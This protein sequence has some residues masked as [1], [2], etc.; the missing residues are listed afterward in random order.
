MSSLH[1]LSTF[2]PSV[3]PSCARIKLADNVGIALSE[4]AQQDP[5]IFVLDGDLA[6]S[7][8]AHHFAQRHPRRFLMA[9][10]AE[11]GMVS[12]A[13]GMAEAGVRPWVFSFAAFLCCRAFDQIRIGVSQSRLPVTLVGSHGGGLSGRNGKTHAA[14]NDIAWMLSL[15][16]IA[17]WAP[18]DALDVRMSVSAILSGS[19]PAYLRTPR[20][21]FAP[22][23]TLPGDAALMRWLAPIRPITLVSTGL[24]SRWAL[25]TAERLAIEGL[26]VG[27]LHLPR[28]RP[29]PAVEQALH[30][31]ETVVII[32]D[33]SRFGGL[34][35]LLAA[36]F[37]G[38]E[39]HAFG[40]P[41]DY[42]GASGDDE[43][44]RTWHGLS[45]EALARAVR[46]IA[47]RDAFVHPEPFA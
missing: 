32:E 16:E 30:G 44:L 43:A 24:G 6:D 2:P 12:T 36:R 27:V 42:P 3:E 33:H 21:R 41:P 9:G 39:L 34:A 22:D 17:V 46:A 10:I 45:A 7:D 40:W 25:E 31:V 23:D 47:D 8:G 14:P 26:D 5:R 35:S 19:A 28:V 11:Q 13:A 38:R 29:L 4:A 15:P 1:V 20:A 18:T 37:P